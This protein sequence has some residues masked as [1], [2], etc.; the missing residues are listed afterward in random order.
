MG[1]VLLIAGLIIFVL[2]F[3]KPKNDGEA[4]KLEMFR[5]HKWLFRIGGFI[6]MA[7]GSALMPTTASQSTNTSKSTVQKSKQQVVSKQRKASKQQAVSNQQAVPHHRAVKYSHAPRFSNTEL[8]N[9]LVSFYKQN[10]PDGMAV[11]MH[12]Q[13]VITFSSEA[14]PSSASFV[15]GIDNWRSGVIWIIFC[16]AGRKYGRTLGSKECLAPEDTAGR[17]IIGALYHVYHIKE[18]NKDALIDV[19]RHKCLDSECT[20]VTTVRASDNKKYM[21]MFMSKYVPNSNH[22]A[23]V[24]IGVY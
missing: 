22:I 3:V 16:N 8:E 17:S 24:D 20:T 23:S 18:P 15:G 2:T 6:V 5:N 10:Y 11:L 7:I 1:A 9:A 14:N 4:K 21:L 12:N 13:I 19:I